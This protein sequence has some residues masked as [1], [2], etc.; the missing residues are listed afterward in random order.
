MQKQIAQLK[1]HP[2]HRRRRVHATFRSIRLVDGVSPASAIGFV[3]FDNELRYQMTNRAL[4]GMMNSIPA[5]R[6][7]AACKSTSAKRLVAPSS[8]RRREARP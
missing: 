3:V 4:A 8:D 5:D 1:Q 7:F 2:V 6:R